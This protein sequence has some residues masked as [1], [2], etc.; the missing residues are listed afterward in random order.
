[1]WRNLSKTV[2][3]VMAA[4]CLVSSLA[5]AQA[6]SSDPPIPQAQNPAVYLNR[7]QNPPEAQL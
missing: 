7:L 2:G 6:Q 3:S 5:M 1:M 4:L